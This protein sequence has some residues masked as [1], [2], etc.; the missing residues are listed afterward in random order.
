MPKIIIEMKYFV[1]LFFS[2]LILFSFDLYSQTQIGIYAGLNSGKLSGDSPENFIYSSSLNMVMG[3]GLDIQLKEDIYL[4]FMPSY[5]NAGSKL[6]Y[7]KEI[8]E[9]QVYEDSISLSFSQISF[10]ILLKLISDN[11]KFQFSGGFELV[12]PFNFSAENTVEKIDLM[13]DINKVIVNMLFGIGYRIPIKNNLLTINLIY[14]QGLTNLA[15]NLEDPDSLLP[16]IRYT[17]FRLTAAWYLP[18][19]KNKFKNPSND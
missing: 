19:G 7:P 5:L 12:F 3:L 9:E 14:S 10:P 11:K 1:I 16:R 17:S 18:L 13:D 6:Q 8:D 15:N 4:S 2:V